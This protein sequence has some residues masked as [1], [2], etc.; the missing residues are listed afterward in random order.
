VI[1]ELLSQPRLSIIARSGD[2]EIARIS[3]IIEHKTHVGGRDELESLFG[4][5]LGCGAPP[6]PKTLDL[7][8]HSSAGKSL[9][10]LGDWVI[11]ASSPTVTA[12]FRGI[13]ENEVLSRLGIHSVRLLGCTTAETAQGRWTI[14]TLANILGVPVYGTKD[15]LYSVH[16]DS[17]GFAAE[18]EY[19]LV[20]S[21][22]LAGEPID[23][24]PLLRPSARPRAL[25]VDALPST[26]LQTRP[27][28]PVRLAS[29]SEGSSLL[30]LVRR[31]HG[32]EMPGLLAVPSC[33]IMLPSGKPGE[34]Y[35]LQVLLDGEFV[36]TY[37]DGTDAPGLL[38]P[39]DDPFA[40][41]ALMEN[42]PAATITR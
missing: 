24:R 35:S 27:P 18:R 22:E 4:E 42:L 30:A 13:A 34:Y 12:F 33:E 5:L 29:A 39:V 28:W 25:D 10:V 21:R 37:P 17:S 16:Y 7:I 3:D 40:L 1:V 38:Y 8:G 14:C 36:R 9:L 2:H 26:T 19:V 15:L 31:Q 6:T 41:K 11:D 20:S 23:P 32:A